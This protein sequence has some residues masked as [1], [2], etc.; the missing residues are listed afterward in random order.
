MGGK[1]WPGEL[2]GAVRGCPVSCAGDDRQRCGTPMLP[3]SIGGPHQKRHG[4]IG[5][6]IAEVERHHAH[7]EGE[8]QEGECLGKAWCWLREARKPRMRQRGMGKVAPD[9]NEWCDYET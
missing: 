7:K 8:C 9:G 6:R 2:A 4:G 5:Q 3:K 1:A